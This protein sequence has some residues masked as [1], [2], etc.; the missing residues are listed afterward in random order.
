MEGLNIKR[1]AVAVVAA[2]LLVA[3]APSALY[4]NDHRVLE[5]SI[6]VE[7]VEAAAR[8]IDGLDGFNTWSDAAFSDAGSN[9]AFHR[10][11]SPTALPHVV[12]TLRGLGEVMNESERTS[13]MGAEAADLL[14]R[15]R[16][17]DMEAARLNS[18]LQQASGLTV[19]M[20]IETRISQ[21]QTQRDNMISR[22]NA[23]NNTTAMPFVYISVWDIADLYVPE[24]EPATLGRR[25]G[26]AFTDSAAY[27]AGLAGNVVIFL[28]AIILPGG[29]LAVAAVATWLVFRK[30]TGKGEKHEKTT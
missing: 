22:L 25:M 4:G 19:M 11:V 6:Q 5:F 28:A 21:V 13:N 24:P 12:G 3:A 8:I 20:E 15:I 26:A 7:D 30:K 17:A 14:A 23:I 2:A 1:A 9:A 18:M 10:R 27:M 29:I 16:A